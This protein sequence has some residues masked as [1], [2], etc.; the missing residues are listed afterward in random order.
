MGYRINTNIGA[1]NAH[2][3]AS[4]NNVGLDRS[5]NSLSSGT[6]YNSGSIK[7]I[8][9]VFGSA[10]IRESKDIKEQK[11]FKVRR[12]GLTKTKID[13]ANFF[14]EKYRIIN[15]LIPEHHFAKKEDVVKQLI[16]SKQITEDKKEIK[17]ILNYIPKAE[18]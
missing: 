10:K 15:F 17:K 11:L 13:K 3:N 1:M 8:M 7:S 9:G 6:Q 16:K 18:K 4:M 12:I 2:R 5:L 14:E